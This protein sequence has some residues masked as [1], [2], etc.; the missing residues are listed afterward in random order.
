VS[1][2]AVAPRRRLPRGERTTQ[3]LDVAEE[4]FAV[5]GIAATTMDDIADNAGVT[6]PVLYDHFG[7][8][9]GLIAALIARGGMELKQ[10]VEDALVGGSTPDDTLA[11]GLHAYFTFIGRHRGAWSALTRETATNTAA[12]QALEAIRS[13]QALFITELIVAEY[14][15]AGHDRA[16]TYAQVVIGACERLATYSVTDAP[17]RADQ[18]TAR[19]MDVIWI[20]FAALRE[21]TRWKNSTAG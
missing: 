19:L 9:D 20:G 1:S 8:K 12:A 16:S 15:E 18:L 7:S 4:V 5:R 17:P 11:R 14:P 21:G 3:L 6:K 13:E 10:D 2:P